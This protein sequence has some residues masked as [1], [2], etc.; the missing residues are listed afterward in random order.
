MLMII[1]IPAGIAMALAGL[2]THT[3]A[4]SF[5]AT[6]PARWTERLHARELASFAVMTLWVIAL[7]MAGE[8][9]LRFE[10]GEESA[11]LLL[12]G[13]GLAASGGLPA[14]IA[15]GRRRLQRRPL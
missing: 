1:A 2:L 5:D 8:A 15:L 13:A 14:L 7:L 6:P 11:W 12:V 9:A 3:V 10:N 4:R